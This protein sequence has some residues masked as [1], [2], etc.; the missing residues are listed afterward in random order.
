MSG[1]ILQVLTAPRQFF[2]AEAE[3][4]SAL[5][6]AA[7][8]ASLAVLG[9]I[10]QAVA[11]SQVSGAFTGELAEI[12]LVVQA[13]VAVF[14]GAL[15]FIVWLLYAVAFFVVSLFFD[16]EG[17]FRDVALLSAWGFL[18][19]I[20]ESVVGI[21]ATVIAYQGREV[22]SIED[23]EA[24]TEFTAELAS[25]PANVAASV[26][27]LALVLWSA[28]IWVAAVQESRH[29]DRREA[30]ITVAVPVAVAVLFRLAGLGVV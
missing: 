28:Y 20:A 17:S 5:Y 26:V 8:V 27:G 16:G 13:V 18:P 3:S 12:L 15:P 19:R 9:L 21:A 30:T 22:P 6:P 4:P 2:A 25:H 14:T 7:I 29:L 23:P 11:F 10:Q 1:G 24:F